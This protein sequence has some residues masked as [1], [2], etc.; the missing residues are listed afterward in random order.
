MSCVRRA[1]SGRVRLLSGW[2]GVI[3]LVTLISCQGQNRRLGY[4]RDAAAV[5]TA[6][7]ATTTE[8]RKLKDTD[9]WY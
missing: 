5:T 7:V 1:R 8:T 6:A 2:L 3:G 9:G 4:P